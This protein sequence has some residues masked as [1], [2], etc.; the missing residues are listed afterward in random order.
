MKLFLARHADAIEYTT[1]TV[2]NDDLRFLTIEGRAKENKV[3]GFLKDYLTDIE[4][5][6]TSPL[7]RAVQTAEIIASNIDYTGEI[8]LV[9]ELKFETPLSPL[10]DLIKT[11]TNYSSLLLVGHEPK[12][13]N[14][15]KVLTGISLA[16]FPKSGFCYI[17]YNTLDDTFKYEWY[18]DPKKMIIIN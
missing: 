9:N 11:M 16:G 1:D 12:L 5:I 10:I 8:V 13:G 4:M 14:L 18:F 2:I 7:I 3:A 6:L 15:V 17:E